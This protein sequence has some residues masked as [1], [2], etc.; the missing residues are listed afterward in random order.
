MY[1]KN[2][3]YKQYFFN[4][5]RSLN[6]FKNDFLFKIPDLYKRDLRSD[7]I[8][9]IK[10]NFNFF[11]NL[12]SKSIVHDN[13]FKS[14]K[15]ETFII[16]HYVGNVI[17]EKD[18]D[19]YYGKVLK[20]L[21]KKT[22]LTLILINH[23]NEKLDEI[24]KKF[25]SSKINRIYLNNNFSFIL[26]FNVL[27]K[28]IIE[29]LLFFF[30]NYFLTNKLKKNKKIGKELNFKAFLNARYTIKLT[31]KII[32][33]LNKSKNI[34]NF[35]TT[36]EGHAFEKILFKYCTEKKIK[37]FGYYFSIIREYKNN[38]YYKFIDQYQPQ[39]VLTSGYH[40]KKF[41]KKNSPFKKNIDILGSNKAVSKTLPLKLD[42]N[43][44]KIRILVCPEGLYSETYE[45]FN[46]I[47]DPILNQDN[48]VFIFRSHPLINLFKI[49]N[50]KKIN[51]NI[52]LSKNKNI[53]YDFIRSDLILYSGSSVCIEAV[54]NGLLPINLKA[55]KNFFSYDPLFEIN[56]FIVSNSN[57]LYNRILN[58]QK[59]K[60]LKKE[61]QKIQLYCKM[62]FNPINS[63]ILLNNLC[64]KKK[65]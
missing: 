20:D 22:L 25:F 8:S 47:N 42:L 41:I 29:Y 19:F 6:E 32:N 24:R 38:I 56:K 30:K 51:K 61:F 39:F 4:L 37:S 65:I 59:N 14:C 35:I 10:V 54:L 34:K 3:F 9:I 27:I 45:M 16:S 62:Y 28:I 64:L 52:I 13:Y 33:V 55:V 49:F 50:D 12:F 36:F 31:N 48:I 11:K 44:K 43:K 18:L 26:D 46:L 1:K 23:T 5:F 40:I 58:L 63:K 21:N 2:I 57:E 15:S 17:K 7:K 53:K 60:K